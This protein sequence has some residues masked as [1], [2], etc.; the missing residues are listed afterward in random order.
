MARSLQSDGSFDVNLLPKTATKPSWLGVAQDEH[1]H[2]YEK[3]EIF[4]FQ[5]S[6]QIHQTAFG[7]VCLMT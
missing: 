4:E 3:T 7:F 2:T 5:K 6:L 1:H